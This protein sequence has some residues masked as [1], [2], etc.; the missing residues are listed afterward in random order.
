MRKAGF[1]ALAVFAS[2]LLMSC[3]SAKTAGNGYFGV[4]NK[5]ATKKQ[6]K[7]FQKPK[8]KIPKSK[9]VKVGN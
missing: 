5:K 9:P 7:E 6:Q 1:I 4:S 3:S 2:S 8:H